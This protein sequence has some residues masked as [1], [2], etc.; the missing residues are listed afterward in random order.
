M[1]GRYWKMV[2]NDAEILA[3]GRRTDLFMV[4]DNEHGLA[5]VQRNEGHDVTLAGFI[6]DDNIEASCARIKIFDNA[7]QWHNPN[8]NGAAALAHLASG[9]GAKQGDADAVAFADAADGVE[10][11]DEC[12]ALA[13]RGA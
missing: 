9:F 7:R 2:L 6:D 11:A 4:T 12:L 10:P 13:R 5:Q 3:N 1:P 8:G